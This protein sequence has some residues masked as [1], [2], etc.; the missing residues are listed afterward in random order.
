MT[1]NND[2][3]AILTKYNACES[4]MNDKKKDNFIETIAMRLTGWVGSTSSIVTHT[5]LFIVFFALGISGVPWN[6]I[7]LVLTTLVSL[8]A[9][10]LSIFIQM[11]VNKHTQ[12]LQNVETDIDE[13]GE[14]ID[15]LGEDIDELG[16]DVDE[17]REDVGE[18]EEHM[19]EMREDVDEM[20]EDEKE[21]DARDMRTTVMLD[22]IHKTV[23]K[24]MED[25][26]KLKSN[27]EQ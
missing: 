24:L 15:E 23:Q 6:T 20:T 26:E 2:S 13:I 18:M 4:P 1:K 21:D 25:I 8:E 3:F 7:L 5:I 19:E 22:N 9:I 10:Y 27:R 16:E 11:T 14:D 17:I 12:S